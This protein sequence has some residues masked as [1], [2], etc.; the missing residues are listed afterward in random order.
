MLVALGEDCEVNESTDNE[1]VVVEDNDN[2]LPML[3]EE[4]SCAVED[5]LLLAKYPTARNSNKSAEINSYFKILCF[6][7]WYY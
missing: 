5:T 7:R 6:M 3:V 4:L 1:T 2:A